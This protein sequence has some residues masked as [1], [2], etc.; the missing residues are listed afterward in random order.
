MHRG[1]VHRT[2]ASQSP[3]AEGTATAFTS[4]KQITAHDLQMMIDPG[5]SV[6]ILDAHTYHHIGKPELAKQDPIKLMPYGG[7]PSLIVMGRCTLIVETKTIIQWQD[8][9]VVKWESGALLGFKPTIN[10]RVPARNDR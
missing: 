2:T 10:W 4:R 1:P 6:N 9:Y 5:A 8:F 3:A 7:G